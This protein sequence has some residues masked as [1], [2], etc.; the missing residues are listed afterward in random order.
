VAYLEHVTT[1]NENTPESNGFD[2]TFGGR[3]RQA[4]ERA[5]MSQEHFAVNLIQMH[6][7][8]WHQTTVRRTESGE[9][10][11]RLSEA[12]AVAELLGVPLDELAYGR[13]DDTPRIERVALAYAELARIRGEIDTQ[14]SRLRR[15]MT[16]S[17]DG[18]DA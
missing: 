6:D 13:G 16:S 14:L 2:N 1:A 8:H 7:I 12:V 17:P 10:P 5:G 18:S 9:R 11:I 15:E 4:R 3:M